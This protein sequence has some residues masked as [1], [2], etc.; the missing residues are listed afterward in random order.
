MVAGTAEE[1]RRVTDY[2]TAGHVDGVLLISSHAGNP[3]V[4]SLLRAGVPTVA[5]GTPL[6]HEGK[7]GYVAADDVTGAASW[8]GT[9]ETPAGV[10]SRPS[11]DR[12]TLLAECSACRGTAT[13]TTRHS[14]PT[15]TTRDWAGSAR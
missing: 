15:A 8:S 10:G 3:V 7:I 1:R 2:V 4:G 14:L 6:G 13:S 5:C 11:P 12:R 9:C